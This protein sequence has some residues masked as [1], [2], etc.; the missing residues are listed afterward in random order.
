[1]KI[2][3][4]ANNIWVKLIKAIYPRDSKDFMQTTEIIVSSTIWGNILDH[5]YMLTNEALELLETGENLN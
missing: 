4:Q 5:I 1:M 3:T 2:L